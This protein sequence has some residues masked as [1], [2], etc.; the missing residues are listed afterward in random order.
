[1]PKLICRGAFVRFVDLRFDEKSNSNYVKLNLTAEYSDVVRAA[2]E[3]EP[4]PDSFE[5]GDLTG[6]LGPGSLL[7]TPNGRDMKKHEMELEFNRVDSFSAVRVKDRKTDAE[8]VELRFCVV[9][10]APHAAAIVEGY[11]AKIGK[12]EGQLRFNYEVQQELPAATDAQ[13]GLVDGTEADTG[14]TACNN[15][16]PLREDEPGKHESGAKCT[17]KDEGATLASAS[18]MGEGRKGARSKPRET[19]VN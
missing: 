14:C 2:M 5:G 12:G 15:G 4:L 17:R 1:M 13:P 7:L 3:W 16:I 11:L 8:T 6:Q 18:T 10:Q 19:P 9:T